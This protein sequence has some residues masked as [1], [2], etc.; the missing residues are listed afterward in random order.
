MQC[1]GKAP[2][3]SGPGGVLDYTKKVETQVGEKEEQVSP[4]NIL[5]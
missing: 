2:V 3:S 1:S 5:E 4:R